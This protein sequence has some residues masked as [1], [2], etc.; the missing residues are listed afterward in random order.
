M[1]NHIDS[2]SQQMQPLEVPPTAAITRQQ[3]FKEDYHQSLHYHHRA[4]PCQLHELISTSPKEKKQVGI[5]SV[6]ENQGH[7]GA[8]NDKEYLLKK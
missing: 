4:S 8:K 6:V 7:A 1:Y 2:Q 5:K 3:T